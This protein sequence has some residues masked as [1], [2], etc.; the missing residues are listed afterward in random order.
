VSRIFLSHSSVD[1]Q[2]A[3]ALK[4]WLVEQN[5]PLDNEI[6]LDVDPN[7]G[8]RPGAKWKDALKQASGRC[9]V[10]ICMVSR[11]W[12]ASSECEVEF[13]TA[14][15]L[16]KRII[17]ARLEPS[18][19]TRITGEWQWVDLFE[20]GA[21]TEIATSPNGQR[22]RWRR[23]GKDV[24]NFSTKG[25]RR[26]R[27]EIVGKG[28]GPD[29]FVW[30]PPNEHDRAPYRGWE[31]LDEFD[32]A[33][34]FGRDAQLVRGLDQLRGMRH[35]G[36]ETL[37]VILGPSGSGKSSFLRAG[38]MPRLRRD[39]RNFVVLDLV[40]PGRGVLTGVTGLAKSL[41]STC[42]EL[43]MRQPR[44]DDIRQAC[45]GD[46]NGFA[47][48]L[49]DIQQAAIKRLVDMPTSA[50]PPTLVLPVD[51]AEELFGVDAGDEAP[52]F[53]ELIRRYSEIEV[54]ERVPLIIAVTIRTDHYD[55]LQTAPQLSGVRAALFDDLKPMPQAEFKE[56]IEGP[57][58]RAREG[59]HPLEIEPELVKRLLDDCTKGADTLPMLALTLWR[60]YTDYG[61]DGD[62]L[63]S[64]Y[65]SMGEMR[66]IVQTEVDSL[67]SRDPAARRAELDLLRSA[68]IPRL[69]TVNPDNDKFVRRTGAPYPWDGL[70][71]E[72]KSLLDKFVDKR[73]LVKDARETGEVV[74]VALES[75]LELWDALKGWL[76]E[77]RE[78]LK[79]AEILK[80]DA[81]TW[82]KNQRDDAWLLQG[83]RLTEAE[84][85]VERLEFDDSA[86]REFVRASRQRGRR[87]RFVFRTLLAVALVG[88]LV[89]GFVVYELALSS[90]RNTAWRLVS[91][92]EQILQ[93]SRAGGDVRAL[94]ELLAAHSLEA[95]A[96]DIV[97][98]NRRDELKILENPPLPDDQVTPVR[99]VAASPDGTQI[100]W[101]SDD[102]KVRVWDAKS[103][104]VTPLDVGGQYA[105]KSVAF[106]PDGNWIA[107]ATGDAKLLLW[108]AK[109]PTLQGNPMQHTQAVMS[110]SFS[111]DSRW[112]ATGSDDGFVRVWDRT[113]GTERI[114]KPAKLDGTVNSV[115]FSPIADR[116]VSGSSDKTV[117][118]LD[119]QTGAEITRAK[120]NPDEDSP[121]ESVAINR[122]GDR[123]A[124]SQSN[125]IV[126]ILDGHT[127][128]QRA[129]FDTHQGDVQSVAFSPDGRRIV[130]GGSDNT[131]RVWD[132]MDRTQIGKPLTG[133]HGMVTSVMFSAD[134]SQIVSGGTDGSV[135]VW[136]AVIGLPIPAGQGEN[137]RAVAFNPDAGRAEMA[138]GGTDGTVKLWNVRTGA[139]I[140][141]LGAPSPDYDSAINTL[142]YN[143][144]GS[145]LLTGAADGAIRVWDVKAR[146]PIKDLDK[147]YPPLIPRDPARIQSVAFSAD[148][149]MIAAAGND[150]VVRLWDARTFR[151]LDAEIAHGFN[152]NG[153]D[154]QYQVWSVAFSPDGHH[155][156][157]GSGYGVGR[158]DL[159][160][161]QLW[162][163]DGFGNDPLRRDGDP[164]VDHQGWNIYGVA[165]D[166][167][168]GRVA[169][170]SYDGT[171]HVF[172]VRSRRRLA[173]M[174][175]DHNPVYTVAFAHKH[176]WMAT[177][178][179]D[180]NIRLWD[181]DTYEPIGTP[182]TGHSGRVAVTF[183]ADDQRILS[184]AE[185]GD[186][187]LWPAPRDLTELICSK[188]T[189]NMSSQQWH[190]WVSRG[191]PS[192]M[193]E[194]LCPN[195][196]VAP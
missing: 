9:E 155:L 133:H 58:R 35:S 20:D 152:R 27:D 18:V 107:G 48:L 122:T 43:N 11:A 104:K 13:R 76:E 151:P 165:F 40:R 127:L 126:Q 111:P 91:E 114:P 192:I 101:S 89:A 157:T 162:D 149:S 51:Q 16:D 105:S 129:S 14:E 160:L 156:A 55:A 194:K 46:I 142:A 110:I 63:L 32:A 71:P 135:R 85:A 139:E 3:R 77:E 143:N 186:I 86:V 137:I 102:K 68:F 115:A 12:E 36:V 112:I 177:A 41:H 26:L 81:T 169:S 47:E 23:P 49:R 90:R 124:V 28:I 83:R 136:D 62:L 25:L 191:N 148:G 140:G 64:E 121:V 164:I 84:S 42:R 108:N 82:D 178:S 181:T 73:L 70:E 54:A 94:Q 118:L 4:K 128:D 8:L 106:S 188:L 6:F 52:R 7:T 141:R 59:P 163:V 154:L 88:A 93:G 33:V 21:S 78:D 2:E 38:L 159:N 134:G 189:A 45:L 120:P 173:L 184:G 100:A 65:V 17:C 123:I 75:L 113:T 182:L 185:D 95:T 39:D 66:H 147:L 150:S 146:Q 175:S 19:G 125:G 97:A 87:R 144:D 74:E 180:G 176:P 50:S 187:H 79:K 153:K 117:R 92:A 67:L 72:T 30:P 131:V 98:D 53:L 24:V 31:P 167:T 168:G 119:A 15:N 1:E 145:R 170:S 172:D 99:R 161:L 174:I 37:F 195:L 5:P 44:L 179:S 57:A 109:T 132:W 158:T 61:D 196:P 116:V 103:G 190:D 69:A 138:S 130:T 22:K 183:D 80:R 29:T 56:V 10:V 166:S 171:V 96:V 34:F 60:L 193:Y